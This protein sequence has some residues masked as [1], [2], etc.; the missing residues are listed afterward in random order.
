MT[1]PCMDVR[2]YLPPKLEKPM[3]ADKLLGEVL[4][5]DKEKG[6]PGDMTQH[7]TCQ[8]CQSPLLHQSIKVVETWRHSSGH[9]VWSHIGPA[10]IQV[11]GWSCALNCLVSEVFW[12]ALVAMTQRVHCRTVIATRTAQN[13]TETCFAAIAL[14]SY[15]IIP[16]CL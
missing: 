2:M 1:H 16:N 6:G 14:S 5:T 3:T 11:F 4:S 9:T 10:P 15:H 12:A 13:T 7:H 8:Q